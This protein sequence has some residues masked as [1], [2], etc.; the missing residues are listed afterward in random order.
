MQREER[1][2]G[3]RSPNY[4]LHLGN[5][6]LLKYILKIPKLMCFSGFWAFALLC[7]F[8][9][10]YAQQRFLPRLLQWANN[11]FSVRERMNSIT[12][13]SSNV[14]PTLPQAFRGEARGRGGQNSKGGWPPTMYYLLIR[15][16]WQVDF[17]CG[18]ILFLWIWAHRYFC[19]E[20]GGNAS[21]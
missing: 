9:I 5:E 16:G 1:S 11:V 7:H 3:K 13:L 21:S 18:C 4:N 19:K 6:K 15:E 12:K 14:Q 17:H 20:K 10:L 8:P 2:Q